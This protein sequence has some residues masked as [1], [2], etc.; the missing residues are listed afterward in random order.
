MCVWVGPALCV[1]VCAV[2]LTTQVTGHRG[3]HS[4]RY[5]VSGSLDMTDGLGSEVGERQRD[6][7]LKINSKWTRRERVLLER[8][9]VACQG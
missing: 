3:R 9:L 1:C 4:Q 8:K 2:S 5:V 6:I 7:M